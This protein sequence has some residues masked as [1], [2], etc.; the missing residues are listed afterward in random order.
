[1]KRSAC[2]VVLVGCLIGAISCGSGT[3][4]RNAIKDNLPR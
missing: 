4:N 1:M 2:R 3:S